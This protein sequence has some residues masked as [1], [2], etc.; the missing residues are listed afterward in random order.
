MDKKEIIRK[1]VN[2]L[3]GREVSEAELQGIDFSGAIEDLEPSFDDLSHSMVSPIIFYVGTGMACI[4]MGIN[5][6][7]GVLGIACCALIPSVVL[8]WACI[9]RKKRAVAKKEILKAIKIC[10]ERNKNRNFAA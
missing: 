7:L 4:L 9:R 6:A 3:L 5:D 2:D 1:Q 10:E 8:G